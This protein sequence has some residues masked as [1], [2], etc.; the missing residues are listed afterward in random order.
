MNKER[1]R[2]IDKRIG[3][4]RRTNRLMDRRQTCGQTEKDRQTDY[5]VRLNIYEGVFCYH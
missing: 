2:K 4:G 5:V 1:K 3:K